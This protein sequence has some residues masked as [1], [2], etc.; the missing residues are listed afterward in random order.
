MAKL[1]SKQRKKLSDSNFAVIQK[2]DGKEDRRFPINDK[3]HARNALARLSQAKGL[4]SSEKAK[5]KNKAQKKLYGTDDNKKIKEVKK[6]K[7][8]ER[9][10]QSN[11]SAKEYKEHMIKKG[12][13]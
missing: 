3:A 4:S 1:T 2:K 9:T 11:M 13:Y 12:K 5:I 10:K 8:S 6:R 7:E